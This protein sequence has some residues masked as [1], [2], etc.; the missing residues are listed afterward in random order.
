MIAPHP[1]ESREDEVLDSFVTYLIGEGVDDPT[2]ID[3]P[4]RV[5]PEH[6]Y[7]ELTCDAVIAVGKGSAD[8]KHWACDVLA[9]AAPFEHAQWP[10]ILQGELDG[11]ADTHG[12]DLSFAGGFVDLADLKR[13]V[14]RLRMLIPTETQGVLEVGAASVRWTASADP[15]AHVSLLAPSP[16]SS[17]SEQVAATLRDPL[18]RKVTHQLARARAQ[19]LATAVLLDGIGPTSLA[20]GTH[21]LPRYP[22][23]IGEA[24]RSVLAE[25]GLGPDAV[26]YL[27]R[28]SGWHLLEGSAV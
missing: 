23:T 21:W 13:F 20:Q 9:L 5:V 12:C 10:S 24:V 22:W 2:L 18:T 16:S 8:E 28:D 19:G 3:R 11:L 14:A 6:L 26:Y 17:L 1:K 4:D 7:P 15:A 27:D 25:A